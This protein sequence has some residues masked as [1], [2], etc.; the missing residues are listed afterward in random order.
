M[1]D[2]YLTDFNVGRENERE[3]KR[4]RGKGEGER[5][6]EGE[7]KEEKER[8]RE[9]K[10]R[11]SNS[12]FVNINFHLTLRRAIRGVTQLLLTPMFREFLS[13]CRCAFPQRRFLKLNLLSV[14]RL[15]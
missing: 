8:E 6:G 9:K 12:V 14:Q 10:R 3:R 1:M 13:P 4:K 2:K 7:S 15:I 5:E 11:R